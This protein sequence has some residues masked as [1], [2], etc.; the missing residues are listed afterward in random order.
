MPR[1][2]GAAEPALRAGALLA[3]GPRWDAGRQRL[4]WVDIEAG[5]LHLFDPASG[6]DR[7]LALGSKVGVAAP[8]RSGPV[9]VALADRLATLDLESGAVRPLLDVPHPT[10]GLR[11][12]DGAVDSAGR[13]W[14]GTMAEDGRREA[15]ALYRLDPGGALETILTGVTLSNGIGWSP[16]GRLMYYVDSG[17]QRVDTIDFDAASGAL[18]GRRPFAHIAPED[19]I[20]DGLTVDDDG[21]VWVALFGGGE[22]RRYLADGALDATVDVPADNV[23]APCF[24][25]PDGRTLYI[26]TASVE[27]PAERAA[28]QPLAG[29]LFAIE[30]GVSGPPARAFAC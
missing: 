26:T 11:T 19:G 22:V 5:E 25:G 1:S 8:T 3:E 17:T 6:L 4:L 14:V 12:N 7:A 29:S 13:L 27:L 10:P 18:T 20:P 23:T 16:D 15:G 21:G 28:L 2:L 30:P 9:L 24:G